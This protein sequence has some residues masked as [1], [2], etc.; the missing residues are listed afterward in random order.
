[1]ESNYIVEME[2]ISKQFGSVH[3]LRNVSI[4]IAPGEVHTPMQA[5]EDAGYSDAGVQILSIDAQKKTM[6]YIK[7]GKMIYGTFTYPWPSEKAI[8]VALDILHGNDVEKYYELE[9]VLITAENVDEYY[10]P[11][12]DY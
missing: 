1:M 8:E 11:S 9:S 6:E 2:G 3:A 4:K 7:E 12:S 5:I 10:D